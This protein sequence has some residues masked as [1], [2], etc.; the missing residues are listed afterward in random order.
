MKKILYVDMDNVLVD[1]PS[2]FPLLS[3]DTLVEYEDRLDE[4]PHIFS[5]MQ[6]MPNAIES[7]NELS[8]LFDTYVLSTSPWG[9]D[10]A[11]S[12]KL[13]WIKKYLGE[14]AYKRLILSHHKHLNI[15]DFLI[16]DRLKNGADKFKGEHIHFGTNDFPDWESVLRYLKQRA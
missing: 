6:P 1:F 7:F 3:E 13:K 11:W 12:D 4:V 14:T 10:T 15:G 8:G 16:D 2:A 9:N 5:L